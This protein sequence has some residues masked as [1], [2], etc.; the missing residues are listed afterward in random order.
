MLGDID[1]RDPPGPSF[2]IPVDYRVPS[3]QVNA[4][5]IFSSESGFDV[6]NGRL[7]TRVNPGADPAHND[8]GLGVLSECLAQG[9]EEV[10]G[11]RPGKREL[12]N[13]HNDALSENSRSCLLESRPAVGQIPTRFGTDSGSQLLKPTAEFGCLRGSEVE[14]QHERCG[15]PS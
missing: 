11:T 13:R 8:S 6:G 1:S 9:L 12:G 4:F 15:E 7:M 2:L 14:A 10:L 5:W 3:V